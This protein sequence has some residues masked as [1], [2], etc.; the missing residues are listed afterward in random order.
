MNAA[1]AGMYG[2]TLTEAPDA[3]QCAQSFDIWTLK[4]VLGQFGLLG[5]EGPAYALPPL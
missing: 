2:K 3:L 1:T 4:L 5:D